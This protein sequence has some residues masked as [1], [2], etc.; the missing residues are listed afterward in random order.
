MNTTASSPQTVNWVQVAPF[1]KFQHSLGEQ[2]F[3]P[4]DAQAIMKTFVPRKRSFFGSIKGGV[5]IYVGHPDLVKQ[6]VKAEIFGWVHALEVKSQALWARVTWTPK[7]QQ[8][9]GE[10]LKYVSPLWELEK[11]N[12]ELHPRK[13]RSLGL[14]NKPN[15]PTLPI[16]SKPQSDDELKQ[17]KEQVHALG[18]KSREIDLAMNQTRQE[19]RKERVLH[20]ALILQQCVDNGTIKP[21][22]R[23][24]W[25]DRLERDFEQACKDLWDQ[26]PV[27]HT[28]SKSAKLTNH[29]SS[30][31]SPSVNAKAKFTTEVEKLMA[32]TGQDYTTCWNAAKKQFPELYRMM[33]S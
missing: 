6:K 8:I 15:I 24:T 18:I 23:E 12:E 7:G 22:E 9:K 1:G 16:G 11:I 21:S 27:L 29:P 3:I 20:M 14:T 4:D 2:V 17:I 5:P 25:R 32:Q 26:R 13:L 19:L 10:V 33:N 28:Q 30:T 31:T